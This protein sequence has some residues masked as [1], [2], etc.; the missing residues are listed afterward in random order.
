ME[1]PND[2][3]AMSYYDVY[4]YVRLPKNKANSFMKILGFQTFLCYP[5]AEPRG[6]L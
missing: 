6:I 3:K 2:I 4:K 5:E 1:K